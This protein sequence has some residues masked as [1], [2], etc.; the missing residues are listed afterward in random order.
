MVEV[1]AGVQINVSGVN[2]PNVFRDGATSV[3][4]CTKILDAY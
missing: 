3:I 2:P 1:F 4:T